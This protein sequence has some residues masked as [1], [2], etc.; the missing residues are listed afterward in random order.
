[1]LLMQLSVTVIY[2]LEYFRRQEIGQ[3]WKSVKSELE[4]KM[5]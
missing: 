1:M 4:Q 5:K 3:F 2:P